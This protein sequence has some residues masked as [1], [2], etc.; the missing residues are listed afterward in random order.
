MALFGLICDIYLTLQ[1]HGN[2]FLMILQCSWI[3]LLL[4]C[5]GLNCQFSFQGNQLSLR[6]RYFLLEKYLYLCNPLGFPEGAS[7]KESQSHSVV[8]DSLQPHGPQSPWSSPGQNTGVGSPS[9]LQGIFPTQGL[10]PG[11]PHC[12]W[13]LYQMSYQGSPVVKRRCKRHRSNPCIRKIPWRRAWQPTP[14]FLPGKSH[15]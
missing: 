10:N 11:L 14:V 4:F 7:G 13:I 5:F 8:S 12:R 3:F 9:L 15:G 2:C 6:H 1:T